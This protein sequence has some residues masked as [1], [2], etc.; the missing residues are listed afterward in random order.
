VVALRCGFYEGEEEKMRQVGTGRTMLRS[1]ACATILAALLLGATASGALAADKEEAQG[2]VDKARVT[3]G[4]FMRDKQYEWLQANIAKAKGVLIYPQV[5]KAGFIWGGSGGTGVLLVKDSKTG[6]WSNPA[7][8][9]MGSVSWGLQIGGEVAEVILLVNSQKG[10]D[11]LL[12]SKFK[13][14]ADASISAGPVGGGAK[15]E[16]TDFVSYAKSKG[17]YAGMNF[18]GSVVDVR[19]GLNKAY[20]GQ[21]TTPVDILVKASVS[22]KGADPLKEELKKVK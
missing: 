13:L 17:L 8:Y 2:I 21:E 20:Y 4:E 6:E 19:E 16:M 3:L 10:V 18:T 22:N 9:T 14:G 12:A 7:F 15:A 11:S 5:V 1:C